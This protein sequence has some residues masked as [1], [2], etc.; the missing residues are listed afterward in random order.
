[1][2]NLSLTIKL[3]E[4]KNRQSI[5]V[6]KILFVIGAFLFSYTSYRAYV[7][8]FTWDEAFSYLQFVRHGILIP[9][10]YEGM[11]ANNHLLNTLLDIQ[12]IK[13]FG[14]SEFVLRM[15]SLFSHLLFLFFSYKLIKNF[16]N[17]W[18]VLASFLIVNLN[19]YLLDFFSLSRGYALSLGL[20]VASI[21]F[22]YSYFINEY[23]NRHAIYCCIFGALA[24]AANF[25]LLNYFVVS[26]GLIFIVMLNNA[27][28]K[29]R[30]TSEKTLQFLKSISVPALIVFLSLWLLLPIVFKL[31]EAEALFYGGKIGFW[32]DTFCTIT[33]RCFYELGY[34]YWF[35]RAAKGFVIFIT[36]ASLMFVGWK[37]IKKQLDKNIL[38]LGGL[39]FMLVM[40]SLSTIVQHYIFGTLYLIDRTAMFLVV[41]FNLT[42]LFF[43][44]E[45]SKEWKRTALVSYIACL[46]FVFH[47]ILSFNLNYV[48][49]WKSNAD[50]K[51][52]VSDLEKVKAIP[53]EK[54]SISICI[55]LSF[56]QSINY[57]RAVNNL[58]WINTVERSKTVNFL[59][60]YLYLEP[61]QYKGINMDS[62]EI[63]KTY[64]VT[65]N[66]LARPKFPPNLTKICFTNVLN[67]EK[68]KEGQYIIDEK[69]EYAQGFSY[70]INDSITND[71]NAE[72]FFK[73]LVKAPDI[74][75]DN[76]YIIIS[77][78]NADGA[79]V[80]K[81][82]CLKDYI[83][84]QDT[85]T[86]VYYTCIVPKETI[87]GDELKSYIW[88]PNKQTLVVKNMELKW[89]SKP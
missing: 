87:A 15:P 86:E 37:K 82:A 49:E 48:L 12:L 46:F 21:Y 11:D 77:F 29:E 74:S 80:W 56:D 75:K 60:D 40:C 79:Y 54:N 5:Y 59:D 6:N 52:M 73:A 13:Y 58:S 89:L 50:V 25:V 30:K 72:V 36:L 26:F 45:L 64:S 38:F 71:K 1:M 47:F 85:W 69:I 43:I 32:T 84:K 65:N 33:D 76:L 42:F 28:Q 81:R 39:V 27:V 16:Q 68:T 19:P 31:K 2:V 78:E 20:M 23:K 63:I 35:Q 67:F 41:L 7:L 53:K 9:D 70:K 18:L 24:T 14:V 22:L 83:I 57:Y 4:M 17:K 8:S 88:N 61:E 51:Q 10:K 62:I 55:P 34:N 3:N 44:N 66:I